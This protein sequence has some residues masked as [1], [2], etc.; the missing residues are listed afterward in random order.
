MAERCAWADRVITA[1]DSA[2][3]ELLRHL[4]SCSACRA[5]R[6]AHDE[7]TEAF[8]GTVRPALAPHFRSQLMTR[9]AEERRRQR[10]VRR[11]LTLLRSYWILAAMVCG[12]VIAKLGVSSSGAPQHAPVFFAFVLFAIPICVLL[13]AIRTNP[14]DLV[15]NT[16]MGTVDRS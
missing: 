2:D 14:V 16:L 6:L 1:G 10:S 12:A 7:L 4:E 3:E 11:R 9:I 8:R 13:I 15:F 5:E